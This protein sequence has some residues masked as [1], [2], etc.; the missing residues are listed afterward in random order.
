MKPQIYESEATDCGDRLVAA[1]PGIAG[2]MIGRAAYERPWQCLANADTVCFGAQSNPAPNRRWVLE[3]FA[4][5]APTVLGE[6]PL[7]E[8]SVHTNSTADCVSEELTR[9]PPEIADRMV[10]VILS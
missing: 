1:S 9:M 5:Y 8:R 2:V 4:E 3:R 10:A 6:A 7:A